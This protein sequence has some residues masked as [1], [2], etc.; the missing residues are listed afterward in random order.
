MTEFHFSPESQIVLD[1]QG[2][3]WNEGEPIEHPNVVR[4]FN[5]WIQRHA[6][7]RYMLKNSISWAY[8]HVLGTPLFV[9][10]LRLESGGEITLMLSNGAEEPWS[11]RTSNSLGVDADNCMFC[12]ATHD[13]PAL[14][15]AQAL[16]ALGP[17]L[18]SRGDAVTIRVR[19]PNTTT[20]VLITPRAL[21]TAQPQIR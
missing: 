19:H 15:R 21:P 2:R 4:A 14:F 20:S 12:V 3:W 8:I 9:E 13:M 10:N 16:Q 7:G 1:R 6:D 17:V 18:E 5:Q 11:E